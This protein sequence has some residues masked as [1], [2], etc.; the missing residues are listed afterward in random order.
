MRPTE[1]VRKAAGILGSQTALA[2]RLDVR[3][4][5]VSQWCSEDRPVPVARALQ[6]EAL[7]GGEVKWGQLCPSFSWG[8]MV[9]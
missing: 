7:T 9:A 5:T 4:P 3:T 6:L 1:A 2:S 8:E